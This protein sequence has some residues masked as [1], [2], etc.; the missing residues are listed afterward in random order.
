MKA[1]RAAY[2]DLLNTGQE[3]KIKGHFLPFGEA[4]PRPG[5]ANVLL[6]GDAAG[7]VDPITGEGIGH[8]IHSG[9][10]AALAAA[11]AIQKNQPNQAF[12]QYRRATRPI[13]HTVVHARLLRPLIFTPRLQPF[14]ARTFTTSRSLKREYMHLLSGEA[15]YPEL[16]LRVLA[17]LPAAS[18]RNIRRKNP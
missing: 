1:H 3:A 7:F 2:L 14:F 11:H 4:K 6:A 16:L 10:L 5:R 8:A 18:L 17:R 12:T 13:R 9:E 15:E